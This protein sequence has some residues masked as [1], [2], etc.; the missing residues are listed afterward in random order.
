[1]KPADLRPGHRIVCNMP[2]FDGAL[3]V[4]DL[5]DQW[6]QIAVDVEVVGEARDLSTEGLPADE[7]RHRFDAG[8][9]ATKEL[10]AR[11][12]KENT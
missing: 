4:A 6:D 5:P 9:A 2:S 7:R 3:V 1:M 12:P 10:L 11:T 8:A